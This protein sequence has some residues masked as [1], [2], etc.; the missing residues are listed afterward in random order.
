MDL[1]RRG[2]KHAK[3]RE[4]GCPFR[5]PG[6]HRGDNEERLPF[7]STLCV[8]EALR[9]KTICMLKLW[10]CRFIKKM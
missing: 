10:L 2:S 8:L 5:A 4:K 9:R 1:A 3:V 7:Q 6:I